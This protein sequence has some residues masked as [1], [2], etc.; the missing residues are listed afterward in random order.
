V[1]VVVE[2]GGGAG[3]G[4]CR[5]CRPTNCGHPLWLAPLFY[6]TELGGDATVAAGAAT[7]PAGAG[8]VG[9]VHC[10]LPTVGS[11]C[12]RGRGHGAQGGGA[13]ALPIQGLAVRWGAVKA[14]VAAVGCGPGGGRMKSWE[15]GQGMLHG[16]GFGRGSPTMGAPACAMCIC[17]HTRRDAPA[18]LAQGTHSPTALHTA[19]LS[20]GRVKERRHQGQDGQAPLTIRRSAQGAA[21]PG[22]WGHLRVVVGG[23]GCR[24]SRQPGQGRVGRVANKQQH[25]PPTGSSATLKQAP[26]PSTHHHGVS[27][28]AEG[29]IT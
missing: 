8:G 20:A 5:G 2:V 14:G 21:W 28:K 23:G 13:L 11:R 26:A 3:G 12:G 15:G 9:G 27:H 24:H 16:A 1:V 7:L 29:E 18:A 6:V 4:A 22:C 25:P 10:S 17:A 19:V